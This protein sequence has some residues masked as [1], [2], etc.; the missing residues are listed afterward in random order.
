MRMIQF[1]GLLS[2][3]AAIACQDDTASIETPL[4][5][6]RDNS[7]LS[8]SHP[9]TDCADCH[10]QH[11]QEWE[12]SNHAYAAKDPV[13]HAMLKLGQAATE[14]KIGQFCIQCHAPVGMAKGQ[15]PV[16]FNEDAGIFEQP[17]DQLD[18]VSS[19]GVSC[20]VCHSITEVM[21]PENAKMVLTP[22]GTK[23]GT[24]PMPMPTDAHASQ[25]SELHGK[26]EL[27]GSCHAV[28]TPRGAL[29][30]ETFGEWAMSSAAQQGKQCQTCHMPTYTGQA[31]P[32]A[33][34][35][36]LHRHT[37]V[38][39]DVSL[40]PP[41]EFPGYDE[42][43]A[44]TEQMLKQSASVATRYDEKEGTL[45]VSVTN[46]SGHALPTGATAERQLWIELLVKN[47]VGEV[48][49]ESGTPDE[50]DDLR[51]AIA[52]HSTRPGSDPQLLY[53]GQFLIEDQDL[54]VESDES[55]KVLRKLELDLACDSII[56]ARSDQPEGV[57]VVT[58]PWQ[59]NWQCNTMIAPDA[60][61]HHTYTLPP[62]ATGDYQAEF[63]LLFRTFPPYFLR[64]LEEQGGLD[65]EVKKRVPTVE[66]ARQIRRF[67]R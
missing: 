37:F 15:T 64:K 63:R 33:P 58:F 8:F 12:M 21:E 25:Y 59:A 1:V 2:L 55:A 4:L 57:K 23:R 17:L 60:T 31:A 40:L 67:R 16:V 13:F 52:S 47:S 35:R 46:L 54:K 32:D 24:M 20:D 41:D 65:T 38:G 66:I 50:N 18:E 9:R 22:D 3:G 26:S 51:D 56:N 39:V 61:H 5:V 10:A 44:L 30:E 14:G 43:R 19:Q 49:F 7:A 34:I 28:T 11:V 45:K 6:T 62:L 27:C 42:M 29:A 36:E 48:V 53:F